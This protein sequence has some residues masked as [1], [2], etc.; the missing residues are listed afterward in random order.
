MHPA[1]RDRVLRVSSD[2]RLKFLA[3]SGLGAADLENTIVRLENLTPSNFPSLRSS[4]YR[5]AE[6][7]A[8]ML[9]LAYVRLTA[10]ESGELP[11]LAEASAVVNSLV[12]C[13]RVVTDWKSI[14]ND[15]G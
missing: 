8:A 6:A 15:R 5:M 11:T 2:L 14:V 12:Y 3:L 10:W 7:L 1:M 9:R 13:Q 4:D